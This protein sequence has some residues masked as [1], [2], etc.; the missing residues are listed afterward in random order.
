ML[1]CYF[2]KQTHIHIV[3]SACT[4]N[5]Q[6]RLFSAGVYRPTFDN[7]VMAQRIYEVHCLMKYILS[8]RHSSIQSTS[9]GDKSGSQLVAVKQII[10]ACHIMFRECFHV[11]YP[12]GVLKWY[13]ACRF[14]ER[15]D[16]V[17]FFLEKI[18]YVRAYMYV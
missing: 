12:S 9:E 17:S 10:N 13:A 11:F 4:T 16:P 2:T 15:L 7:P 3:T 6:V 8:S 14:L 18:L 1:S 5:I